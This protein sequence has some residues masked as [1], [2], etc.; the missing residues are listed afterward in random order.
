M[1]THRTTIIIT[2]FIFLSYRMIEQ[3]GE[4]VELSVKIII[5][6]EISIKNDDVDGLGLMST[7][8]LSM[9]FLLNNR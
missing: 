9:H 7:V 2:L 4:K 1:H 6:I 8:H 3:S 5:F